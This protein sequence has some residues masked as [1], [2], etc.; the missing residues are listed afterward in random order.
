MASVVGC[1]EYVDAI[2]EN[3]IQNNSFGG[4]LLFTETRPL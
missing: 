3:V 1:F 4:G 2:A